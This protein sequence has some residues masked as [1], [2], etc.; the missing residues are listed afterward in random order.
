MSGLF[1]GLRLDNLHSSEPWVAEY[2]V[3]KARRVNPNLI[4]F[5]ELFTGDT[6]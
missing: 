5:A 3:D 1:D 2:L 4:V 6:K